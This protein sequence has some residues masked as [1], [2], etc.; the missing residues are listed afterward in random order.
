MTSERRVTEALG[1][2]TWMSSGLEEQRRLGVSEIVEA[3][4]RQPN[5]LEERVAGVGRLRTPSRIHF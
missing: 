1:D 2:H 5:P 4:P 3:N